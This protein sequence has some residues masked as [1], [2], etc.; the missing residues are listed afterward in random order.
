MAWETVMDR[1]SANLACPRTCQ[2]GFTLIELMIAL[3]LGLVIL[4]VL[5]TVFFQT[6]QARNEI[7]KSNQQIENGRYALQVLSDDLRNAGYL[8]EF[9]PAVLATP[10]SKPDPCATDLASLK[11]ALPISIQGY[12]AGAAAPSC[13]SDVRS[14]T[15]ILV[16]RRASSCAVGDA[17]CDV[18]VTGAPYFQASGCSNSSELSSASTSDFYRLD[19]STG[20]LNR[21]TKDCTTTAPYHQYRVHIYFIAN[22]DKSGDGIPTLKRAELG[23]AGF[24]ITPLVEGIDDMQIEYGIDTSS[25]STGAPAVFTTDPDNYAACSGA[26]CV[27]YWRNTVA[28]KVY[29]LAR[30]TAITI[31]YNSSKTYYMGLN[32]SG[33]ANTV[34]PFSDNYKRHGYSALVRL[35][36][37]SGRN[38]P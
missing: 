33:V 34:G 36:N 17:G 13:V 19:T 38:T 11:A 20:N 5:T 6:S 32:A 3:T 16:V 29:L 35:N 18:V 23:A 26:T 22:N 12:A 37:P 4:G 28:A 14:N 27:G 2:R 7:E 25:P 8:A 9:D 10:T 31:N 24:S 21:H 30:N 1:S 15:A